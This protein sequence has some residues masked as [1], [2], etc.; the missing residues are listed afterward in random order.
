MFSYTKEKELHEY[1]VEHFN[2]YFDFNYISS[3]FIVSGGRV[4]IIGKD[5]NTIYVVELKRDYITN[6]AIKQLVNY[7]P[8]IQ[9]LNPNSKVKG[10]AVAPM[11][12]EKLDPLPDNIE[13]MVLDNVNFIEPV[14]RFTKKRVTFTIE[15]ELVEK[16]KEISTDTM[17]PQAKLV[18]KA[19][20]SI[21]EKYDKS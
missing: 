10:I 5:D 6:S 9:A 8:E 1:I 7:L 11:V 17:I 4:D 13:L 14:H 18:E 3:E 19:I 15:E 16:L 12:D 20:E 21:I 2:D